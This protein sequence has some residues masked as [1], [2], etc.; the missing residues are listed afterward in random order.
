MIPLKA[1]IYSSAL[2]DFRSFPVICDRWGTM[3]SSVLACLCSSLNESTKLSIFRKELCEVIIQNNTP[4]PF[5]TT[6]KGS[7]MKSRL[8]YVTLAVLFFSFAAFAQQSHTQIGPFSLD[9][10]TKEYA[11]DSGKGDRVAQIEI[12]FPTPFETKPD[13]ALA[14]NSVD[15]SKE[16]N[17][18]YTVK[19]IGVSRD[20]FTL[21][22]KTW[23]DS[24]IFAIG[25]SWIAVASKK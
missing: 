8:I 22:V 25:G 18:R 2:V 1:L 21:Q 20:G 24:K 17:L 5:T 16:T 14:V 23:E 19:A 3:A 15:A 12:T 11:L 13:I 6:Q 9:K 4:F 7:Q 10:S